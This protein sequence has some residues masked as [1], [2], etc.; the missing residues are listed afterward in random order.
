MI[1]INL[2]PEEYWRRIR[3]SIKLLAVGYSTLAVAASLLAWWAW[4]VAV[5]TESKWSDFEMTMFLYGLCCLW[6]GWFYSGFH[7]PCHWWNG[8]LHA[9]Q[10]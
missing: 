8:L 7:G 4:L 3:P 10:V 9:R 1:T 6:G 2:L 5:A